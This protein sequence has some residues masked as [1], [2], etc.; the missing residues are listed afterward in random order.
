MK[1]LDFQLKIMTLFS[2][3]TYKSW[4]LVQCL[5]G[6]EIRK[7]PVSVLNILGIVLLGNIGTRAL[8]PVR[9]TNLNSN[10]HGIVANVQ[11]PPF[12]HS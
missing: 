3:I 6:M 9:F 1:F 2:K 5:T 11:N 8:A 4:F 7:T 12:S 10:H